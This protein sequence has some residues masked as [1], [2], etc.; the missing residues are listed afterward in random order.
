MHS[1][2]PFNVFHVT[3]S[4]LRTQ[5]SVVAYFDSNHS[6]FFG[7]TVT[8]QPNEATRTRNSFETLQSWHRRLAGARE[9]TLFTAQ[10]RRL[11][12]Q[13]FLQ[14]CHIAELLQISQ[15]SAPL[16]ATGNS[17][18]LQPWV[19]DS[20]KNPHSPGGAAEA[21]CRPSGA[22]QYVGFRI[23]RTEVLGY[24]RKPLPGLTQTKNLKHVAIAD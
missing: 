12:H 6:G 16:G 1:D 5:F 7:K 13:E 21:I 3:V 20:H 9:N 23:P 18:R 2:S 22:F 24:Y 17:P 10:A 4:Q 8:L 11:C 19:D 15:F 14:S